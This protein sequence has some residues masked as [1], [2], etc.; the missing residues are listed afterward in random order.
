L[1]STTP[2]QGRW[3]PLWCNRLRQQLLPRRPLKHKHNKALLRRSE[4]DTSVG[5]RRKTLGNRYLCSFSVANTCNYVDR[6]TNSMLTLLCQTFWFR[7]PR[8]VMWSWVSH[9]APDHT[10]EELSRW[11]S[12]EK[13]KG[14]RKASLCPDRSLHQR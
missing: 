12:W 3:F 2:D 11:G 9:H 8:P 5:R 13:G 14:I 10:L 6:V 7:P 1:R 4:S